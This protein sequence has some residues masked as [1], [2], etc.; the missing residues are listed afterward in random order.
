MRRRRIPGWESEAREATE[1]IRRVLNALAQLEK[2]VAAGTISVDQFGR[3]LDEV[4]EETDWAIRWFPIWRQ[5][6]LSEGAADMISFAVFSRSLMPLFYCADVI[7]WSIGLAAIS[8]DL[9]GVL[10][11]IEPG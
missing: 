9:E 10:A 2:E 4:W 3:A 11:K 6:A 7:A 8:P 1:R 5:R